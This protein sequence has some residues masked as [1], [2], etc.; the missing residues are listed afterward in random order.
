MCVVGRLVA[1]RPG[2][3][4]ALAIGPLG[5]DAGGIRLPAASA[6][7]L[8]LG[9]EHLPGGGLPVGAPPSTPAAMTAVVIAPTPRPPACF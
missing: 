2:T 7:R 4:E 8:L 3:L 5:E 6:G 1:N 9:L